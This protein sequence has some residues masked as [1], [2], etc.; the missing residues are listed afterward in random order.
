VTAAER[1]AEDR[2][3]LEG[4]IRDLMSSEGWQ[5]WAE[6]R[7][8]FHSYSFHNTLMIA[9]QCP[10]ATRVA[11]YRAWQ[12]LGRQV[13][14]GERGIKIFAPMVFRPKDG[15]DQEQKP[16][17]L[18][19]VVSVFDIAQTDGEPLPEIPGAPIEGD[20]HKEHLATLEDF[21][22]TLGYSVTYEA[23]TGGRKGYCAPTEHRIV[24]ESAMAPN[25]QVK[26]LVHE[27]AHALGVDYTDYSR[28]DAEVIVEAAAF[29]V[30]GALGL[31]TSSES[32]PYV[33]AWGEANDLDAL[34]SYAAT[35]D[36]IAGKLEEALGLG[37]KS[38][39]PA[40]EAV[41]A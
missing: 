38:T 29:I 33:A 28:G 15:D 11:G 17:V 1:R 37:R 39:G 40:A 21:A 23:L 12:K 2:E 14:K 20:S 5:R 31:D 24:I 19:K 10:S 36:E 16:R 3:R 9:A 22:G 7:S 6:T 41:A 4:A 8:R 30:C 27:I 35:V 34:K 13:R 26:V 18:F 32:L 25:R